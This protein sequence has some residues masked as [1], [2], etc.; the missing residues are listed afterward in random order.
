MIRDERRTHANTATRIGTA[1][2]ML[3]DYAASFRFPY[4]RKDI[5]DQAEGE[6]GFVRGLWVK[7]KGVFG[8][9]ENGDAT[10]STLHA[11]GEDSQGVGMRAE[12]D[13][14]I[15]RILSV[16]ES[17]KTK[18]IQSFSWD[19]DDTVTGS[20]WQLTDSDATGHSRLVVDNLTVRMKAVFQGL[21]V[22]RLTAMGG[23]YVFSPAAGVIEEVD[24]IRL[25]PVP[26]ENNRLTEELLGYEYVRVP[27]VLR[28]VPRLLRCR[29]L[30]RYK[31]VR[32]PMGDEDWA[33]VSLFRCWL[34]SDDGSTQ[35]INTWREG[36]LARC[37][38]MD[39]KRMAQA[40]HAGSHQGKSVSNKLYWRAVT[41]TGDGVSRVIDDGLTHNYVDLSNVEPFMLAGSDRPSAGDSI[42][43][44]GD[45]L[46][47]DTSNI[48]T[49]E[50]LGADAPAIKEYV[51]VG[52]R[53]GIVPD[54][55]SES[56]EKKRKT[57][58]SPLS[59]D[60]FYAKKFVF[61]TEDG[62]HELYNEHLQEQHARGYRVY[63]EDPSDGDIVL[64]RYGT[65]D[66]DMIDVYVAAEEG[67]DARQVA[68]GTSYVNDAD[69]HLYVATKAGWEK[70][71]VYNDLSYAQWYESIAGDLQEI[72]ARK[73][74][75]AF[76]EAAQ[77]Y[78]TKESFA[79]YQTSSTGI[80]S[81]IE[82]RVDGVESA[83][84]R[85]ELT[86]DG[87]RMRVDDAEGRIASVE[88]TASSIRLGVG[89]AGID[90]EQG[91]IA[92]KSDT[93]EIQN[94]NGTTTF[95][96][97]ADGNLVGQGNAE[98]V[99]TIRAKTFF[100]DVRR[101][102]VAEGTTAGANGMSSAELLRATGGILPPVLA[103]WSP[104]HS[105]TQRNLSVTLPAAA[106]W[107]GHEVEIV[108]QANMYVGDDTTDLYDKIH[109]CTENDE[110][111]NDPAGS[112]DI[113]NQSNNGWAFARQEDGTVPVSHA[114]NWASFSFRV[115]S[116]L[117]EVNGL[118]CYRWVVLESRN[119][120][121]TYY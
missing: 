39:V 87:L 78:V 4:I 91:K 41:G 51:G 119:T 32:T 26:G 44:F 61:V 20:G 43:C 99:G 106:Q 76:D 68:M 93:F 9:G 67:W 28:F 116:A 27:F 94:G 100:R 81:S 82:E 113:S 35:T 25:L 52:Y 108:V 34:K 33:K 103:L 107:A 60:V 5:D 102:N 80:I 7:A 120:R 12:K 49:I 115:V 13:G 77:D 70:R 105:K 17:V 42:V 55:T 37:Q 84:S 46:N 10:V 112:R 40:T 88:Q 24:Y 19:G 114:F 83:S 31:R 22:R 48:V 3:L 97:D 29:L 8:I 64:M 121:F 96:V 65:G 92:A 30:S 11:T 110:C 89:N 23:N 98:F 62:E 47:R 50:T 21:E 38:T 16:Y 15:G 36:M 104:N 117:I 63:P 18:A 66:P 79:E 90:I 53:D 45:Y 73:V 86:A 109:V 59:G 75:T 69:G 6:V 85:L 71:G 74:D 1:L 2:L 72:V 58:L 57:M 95:S 56:L 54:F 101:V 118:G 111:F 14:V